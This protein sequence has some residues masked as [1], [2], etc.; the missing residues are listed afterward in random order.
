MSRQ[1]Q[2]TVL[3]LIPVQTIY[4]P[5]TLKFAIPFTVPIG[6]RAHAIA[7]ATA[8]INNISLETE[9]SLTWQQKAAASPQIT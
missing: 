6:L 4:G 7:L 2:I 5:T 9:I 1:F 8:F 3:Q